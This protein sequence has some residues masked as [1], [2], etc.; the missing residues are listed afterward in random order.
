MCVCE[1]LVCVLTSVAA[2][3]WWYIENERDT[4][5]VLQA[6]TMLKK[7]WRREAVLEH[8][9]FTYQDPSVFVKSQV[10]TPFHLYESY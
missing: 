4:L 7:I 10:S 1:R 9:S 8:I 3:L 5:Q 6:A 2:G